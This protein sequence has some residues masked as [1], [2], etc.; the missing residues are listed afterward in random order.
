MVRLSRKEKQDKRELLSSMKEMNIGT[1]KQ[2]DN[3]M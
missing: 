2:A 1:T 3:G